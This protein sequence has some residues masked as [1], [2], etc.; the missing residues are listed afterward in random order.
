MSSDIQQTSNDQQR[1]D[2]LEKD[3]RLDRIA[4]GVLALL[5]VV[6]LA[7]WSTWSLMRP[8]P[9]IFDSSRF[10]AL[11]Q[12]Q[13]SLL[14]QLAEL[15]Q[16][17]ARL[18]ARPASLPAPPVPSHDDGQA[19]QQL[20]SMLLT[21]EQGYQHSLLAL[22]NGMRDLAGMIAGSRSW[23]S[24]YNEALDKELAASQARLSQ[25][26]GWSEGELSAAPL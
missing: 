3:R 11:E 24:D 23:L 17:Q 12:R 14:A 5:L 7:S 1:L 18:E 25:L 19:L 22:K 21:Q 6:I 13:Q 15:Q 26:Q 2:D 16:A 10:D 4:L 8:E 9:E 20:A